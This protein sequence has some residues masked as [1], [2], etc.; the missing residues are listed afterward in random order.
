[1]TNC[2]SL[3][4]LRKKPKKPPPLLPSLELFPGGTDGALEVKF[5]AE[6]LSGRSLKLRFVE[7][8]IADPFCSMSR[9]EGPATEAMELSDGDF[10]IAEGVALTKAGTGGFDAVVTGGG[11]GFAPVGT[12]G[13]RCR[14]AVSD[15]KAPH[16]ANTGS[17]ISRVN[18][19][20]V[21][22]FLF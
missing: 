2:S 18:P 16:K 14:L 9:T 12:T 15:E 10:F 5:L 20:L 13:G 3:S 6:V 8:V 17:P 4:F 7:R 22:L 19:L 21:I 11:G 1:M